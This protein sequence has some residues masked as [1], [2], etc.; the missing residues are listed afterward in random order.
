MI[1]G[2]EKQDALIRE[3]LHQTA[4]I[5]D[6]RK[7]SILC[8]FL[9]NARLSDCV[10]LQQTQDGAPLPL[11]WWNG[12]FMRPKKQPERTHVQ[13]VLPITLAKGVLRH[14]VDLRKGIERQ[15]SSM[16]A[17]RAGKTEMRNALQN[18]SHVILLFKNAVGDDS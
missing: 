10:K 3:F 15:M 12:V 1:D 14:L 16:A 7:I 11:Y 18:T 4:A 8:S 13:I 2:F 9:G 17:R 5:S 6:E